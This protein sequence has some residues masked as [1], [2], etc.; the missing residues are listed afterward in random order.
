MKMKS[1]KS[2]L[3]FLIVLVA[4]LL[5]FY[6]LGEVPFGFNRDEASIGYN[7][8]SILKTGKDEY[9]VSWPIYFKSVG[10]YKLPVYF[11]LATLPIS[12]FGLN[13]WS[14]RFP[15]ALL[16]TL[17][18][19]FLYHLVNE[20]LNKEKN[21]EEIALVSAFIL[22]IT[23]WHLH[24]SR[25][26]FEVVV[27]LFFL[28]LGGYF[29][30]R[31]LK[32]KT[33]WLTASVIAFVLSLY[34]YNLTR[35]L[36]PLI[37]LSFIIIYRKAVFLFPRRILLVNFFLGMFLLIPF[38]ITFFSRQGISSAYGN[39]IFTSSAVEASIFEF[40]SYLTSW[41]VFLPI[42]FFNRFV[43]LLWEWIK[44]YYHHL[45]FDFLFISGSAH[46]NHGIGN[47][48]QL[49]FWQ[50]IFLALGI[51][52]S[53]VKRQESW[54]K[55]L[56]TWLFLSFGVASLTI[57]APHATRS[58]FAN[59][60][61]AV[62]TALGLVSAYWWCRENLTKKVFLIVIS[63]FLLLSIHNLIFYFSSYYWRFPTFYAKSWQSAMKPLAFYLKE[64]ERDYDSVIIDNPGGS[65]Y[66]YLLFFLKYSPE[67]Y[68][69]EVVRYEPDEEGFH[70]V[71]SFGKYEFRDID[72]DRDKLD[73]RK[74]LFVSQDE[75]NVPAE[76]KII[77]KFYYPKRTVAFPVKAHMVSYPIEEVAYTLFTNR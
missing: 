73:S 61:L 70:N 67:K 32:G 6:K 63:I 2:W 10:D 60:P 72:W 23:P 66:I 1:K 36:S 58:F 25:A 47:F 14:V 48:G 69:Q 57:G 13:E 11:Y 76:A 49:Y 59:P 4:F 65:P 34:S 27:A 16:G 28:V 15:S 5:R 12:I 50:L 30:L 71:R 44:N 52:V 68:L 31:S 9:G 54:S 20:L 18:V 3:L 33:Y 46:G 56:L 22:A 37:F 8:Y 62:L 77:K 19:F 51:W 43:L 7:A 21:K 45:S 26:A 55:I 64:V 41:P 29:F 35:L 42:L 74:I 38:L 24:F 17:T 75:K 40:R 39:L 53:I